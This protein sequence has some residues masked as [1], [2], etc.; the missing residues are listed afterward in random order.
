MNLFNRSPRLAMLAGAFAVL[1]AVQPASA[2]DIS[3]SH[4]SAARSAIA[5]LKA[6]DQF[7]GILPQAAQALKTELIQ[8]NPDLQADIIEIVDKVAFS[9]AARRGDLERE[10][11]LAYAR[12]FTEQE[13]KEVAA[14]YESVAGQKLLTEGPVVMRDV[15]RAV[16]IWQN[17]IARDLAQ[18]VA[19]ELGGRFGDAV[20]T[21]EGGEAPAE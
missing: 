7:D 9:L 18:Q 5:A 21:E 3:D 14:F 1:V 8:K 17:G 4:L 12:V 6:T 20:E 13:L 19:V 11:A 10:A 16:E 2:Q 15:F